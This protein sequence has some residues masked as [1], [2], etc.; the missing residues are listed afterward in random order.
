MSRSYE[1]TFV[2]KIIVDFQNGKKKTSFEKLKEF[3]NNNS[4][5]E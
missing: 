3:V 2:N 5:D 4:E 1:A